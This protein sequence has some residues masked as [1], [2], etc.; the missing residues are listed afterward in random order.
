MFSIGGRSNSI[1][2]IL[3]TDVYDIDTGFWY[4]VPGISRFR[5]T[6]WIFENSLYIHGGLEPCNP[7]IPIEETSKLDLYEFC[8]SSEILMKSLI[9]LE[10]VNMPPPENNVIKYGPSSHLYNSTINPSGKSPMGKPLN[11]K[12]NGQVYLS[13]K[14]FIASSYH[15]EINGGI[16]CNIIRKISIIKL[17]EESKKI[18]T[19]ANSV[20]SIKTIQSKHNHNEDVADYFIEQLLISPDFVEDIKIQFEKQYL[21]SLCG[22]VEKIILRDPSL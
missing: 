19:N 11:H 3:A 16:D 6:N 12:G 4:K 13:K 2:E 14:A 22:E 10:N 1:S 18:G 8:Q 21:E 15:P 20:S 5:Q 9:L 7:N 17:Q